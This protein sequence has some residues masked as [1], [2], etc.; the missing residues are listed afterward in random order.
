MTYLVAD[1]YCRVTS[2]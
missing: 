1:P 2:I